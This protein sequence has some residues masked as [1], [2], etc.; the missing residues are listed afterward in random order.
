MKQSLFIIFTVGLLSLY[1]CGSV[2]K[3]TGSDGGSGG[4]S[5]A[6]TTPPT[7][8]VTLTITI[9]PNVACGS[10]TTSPNGTTFTTNTIVEATAV[11]N[12]GYV[13]DHWEDASTVLTTIT[14]LTMNTN[15]TLTAVFVPAVAPPAPPANVMAVASGILD[16]Y[17][18]IVELTGYSS[19]KGVAY[20]WAGPNNY[21]S[22]LQIA[23]VTNPGLYTLTVTNPENGG[24]AIA[25][26]N[27]EQDI[28]LPGAAI[29]ASGWTLS[30]ET[31]IITLTG[32]SPTD[33]VV[34]SW[35][36]PDGSF[37]SNEQSIFVVQPGEYVL[38][39]TNPLNG[40]TS[41]AAGT[42]GYIAEE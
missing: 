5:T 1:G 32:R 16:G 13:F 6:P 24:S 11:A 36:G 35:S 8:S 22:A 33:G 41:T 7:T 18:P 25:T 15:K 38:T 3:N 4:S 29:E 26:I 30:S 42:V 27:V 12:S 14:T 40:M 17:H 28:A 9:S 23:L 34:Y 20:F 39:V 21:T 2:A 19:T 37:Y 31:P 10:V